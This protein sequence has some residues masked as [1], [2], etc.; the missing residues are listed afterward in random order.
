MRDLLIDAI[1]TIECL[2]TLYPAADE[3]GLALLALHERLCAGLLA[4][5]ALDAGGQRKAAAITKA[6]AIFIPVRIVSLSGYPRL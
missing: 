5:D 6:M 1:T 4:L 2:L 3:R